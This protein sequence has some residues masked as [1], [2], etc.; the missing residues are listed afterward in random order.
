MYEVLLQQLPKAQQST[1]LE[2]L[3]LAPKT[4]AV[5]TIHRPENVDNPQNLRNIATALVQL[6][7]LPVIFPV[8]PRTQKQLQKIK[9]Y[10]KLQENQHIKLIEPVGYH[11][12]L[13]LIQNAKVVLTDS[14]GVQKEAF[15]SRTPCITLR[16]STEWIETVNLKANFLTGADTKKI[17]KA[18]NRVVEK[19]ETLRKIFEKISNPFGDGKASQKILETILQ[20]Y[21]KRQG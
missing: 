15:W 5:L 10:R 4:Y 16:E 19:E 20:Y 6:K 12:M 14:G 11:E 21:G 1:V 7:N 13:W 17:L 3:C 2:K 9:V 8:H 18:V